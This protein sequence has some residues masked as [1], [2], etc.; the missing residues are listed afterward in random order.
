MRKLNL[1]ALSIL[2]VCSVAL[3]A[4]QVP[5]QVSGNR[6][7]VSAISAEDLVILDNLLADI[8]QLIVEAKRSDRQLN[9]TIVV[10]TT[11]VAMLKGK[12]AQIRERNELL[13]QR[14]RR[15]WLR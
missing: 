7:V 10:L 3:G 12:M 13:D 14:N 4:E 5:Q 2:F 15:F 8:K 1:P 11:D 6:A 9:E